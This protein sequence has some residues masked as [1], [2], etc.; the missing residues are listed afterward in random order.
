MPASAQDLTDKNRL[1]YL[2]FLECDA[3]GAFPA[4]AIVRRNAAIIKGA[5]EA[6]EKAERAR[7]GLVMLGQLLKGM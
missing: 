1:A 4:D 5:H 2:H 6:A 7:S 3:V